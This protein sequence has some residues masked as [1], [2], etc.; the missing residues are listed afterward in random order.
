MVSRLSPILRYPGAKWSLAPW[1]CS[2]IPEHAG[3]LEPFFGSGAV[4]FNKTPAK[5]ETIND[6]D[7]RV[8]NLFRVLREQPEGLA[9]LIDA[10]PWSRAEYELSYELVGEG[11]EDARRFLVRCWQ[12]FG[13][14]L[15]SRSGWARE[16]K[17]DRRGRHY[18]REWDDL[19]D[20]IVAITERLKHVQLE[21]RPA[22][23][24]IEQFR[25]PDVLIYAD[26]PYPLGTRG[27]KNLYSN[28]MTD[29]DHEDLLGLLREHPGP[30]LISTYANQLYEDVLEGWSQKRARSLAQCGKATVEVLWLNPQVA[31]QASQRELF[32]EIAALCMP[33]KTDVESGD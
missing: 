24:L 5:I 26:P 29:H 2:Q 20:R 14:K 22:L 7:G 10:T 16:I 21:C 13:V 19:P 30:V 6:I 17:S 12:S 25:E 3:Y 8:V 28:E 4:Y 32:P 9:Q 31:E 1:I 11:L 33:S 27:S 18:T 15:G 23:G